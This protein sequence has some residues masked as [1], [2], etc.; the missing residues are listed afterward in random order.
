VAFDTR[1]YRLNN[2][3]YDFLVSVTGGQLSVSTYKY[4]WAAVSC[5]V[6][7]GILLGADAGEWGGG[8]YYAPADTTKKIF[9]VNGRPGPASDDPFRGGLLLPGDN[10]LA[11]QVKGKFLITRGNVKFIFHYGDSLYVMGGL[12]HMGLNFG[13]LYTLCMKSDSFVV[14]KSMELDS[15]PM[16]MTVYNDTIYVATDGGFWII[17][18]EQKQQIFKHLFWGGG[19]YPNSIAVADEHHVYVGMRGGYATIDLPASNI[20]FYQYVP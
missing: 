12:A 8:L 9:F 17:K 15:A 7:N 16:A 14:A 2:S 20:K 1:W 6:K 19:L 18:K 11:R 10:P 13:G 4:N 5:P 3:G